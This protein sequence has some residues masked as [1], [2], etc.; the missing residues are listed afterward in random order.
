MKLGE[1][2]DSRKP[3][4]SATGLLREAGLTGSIATAPAQAQ[5]RVSGP[6]MIPG[7]AA[8][9][10]DLARSIAQSQPGACVPRASRR[11]HGRIYYSHALR[12]SSD[13]TC[14]A[15]VSAIAMEQHPKQHVAAGTGDR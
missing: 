5:P 2:G 7:V 6:G 15:A 8:K 14:R 10:E 12:M 11:W 13:P 9:P 4:A 3:W 1:R